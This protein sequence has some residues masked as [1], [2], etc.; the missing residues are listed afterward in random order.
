[1]SRLR[2]ARLAAGAV[3][4]V[5][6]A[7]GCGSTGGTGGGYDGGGSTD[8]GGAGAG[9]GGGMTLE[10][11]S[12]ADGATVETP[13]TVELKSSEEL[14]APDTGKNHVHVFFDGNDQEYQVV[15][16]NSVEITDLPA[17]DHEIDASLRN[18]DHS[19]AGVETQVNVTVG[20]GGSTGDSTG[21]SGGSY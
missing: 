11:T 10:I 18:A 16:G 13:F 21:D 12:P 7:A 5:L 19:A 14:G 2:G 9:A 6:L 15:E 3:L 8:S 20:S 1:M 4:T 17:G